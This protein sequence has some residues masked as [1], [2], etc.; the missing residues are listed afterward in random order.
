MRGGLLSVVISFHMSCP[1]WFL[2]IWNR[3]GKKNRAELHS[4]ARVSG[5]I[6]WEPGEYGFKMLSYEYLSIGIM[7]PVCVAV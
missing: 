6:V 3:R 2:G 1:C 5:P 4:R 7:F